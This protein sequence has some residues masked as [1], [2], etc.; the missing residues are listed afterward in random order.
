[1][2]DLISGYRKFRQE[3]WPEQQKLYERLAEGQQPKTLVIACADSRVDPSSI[4][5][6]SPGELFVVRNVA[7]VVPPPEQGE[8]L[9]GTAAAIEF[10]ITELKVERVLVMGHARCGGVAAAIDRSLA[11]GK[12][13]LDD[14]V[15]LLEEAVERCK[16]HDAPINSAVEREG[17]RLSLERL[18]QY[19]FVQERLAKGDLKLEGAIFDVATGELERMDPNSTEFV[20]VS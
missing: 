7:N 13:Y 10:A 19:P 14:W 8:G 16:G 18:A 5:S 20:D 9:H 2:D 12:V 15:A 6:A 11:A 3:R 1:M 4:F 17:V